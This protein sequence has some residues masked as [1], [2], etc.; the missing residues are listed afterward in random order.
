MIKEVLQHLSNEDV[1]KI[2]ERISTYKYVIIGTSIIKNGEYNIDIKPGQWRGIDITKE[3]FNRKEYVKRF[4][5]V[6]IVS[7][8]INWFKKL[9]GL[10]YSVLAIY[11]K[12]S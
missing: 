10:P 3:P 8:I 1:K 6:E 11:E 12:N 5:Y 2:L 9:L 7:R 4:E